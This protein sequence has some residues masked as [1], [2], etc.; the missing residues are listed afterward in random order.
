MFTLA[1]ALGLVFTW[2]P[3]AR[4]DHNHDLRALSHQ[5]ATA[6]DHFA[7]EA[8]HGAHHGSFAEIILVNRAGEF[9]RKATRLHHRVH[10]GAP[11]AELVRDVRSLDD[12][13]TQI[14]FTML[15]SHSFEHLRHDW[16]HAHMLL[17]AIRR[18]V[19]GVV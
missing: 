3:P 16:Q 14:N 4:A 5:L 19:R 1:L 10:A 17:G 15:F 2:A 7:R 11:I 18:I 9:A 8:A 6:A 12:L 13:A